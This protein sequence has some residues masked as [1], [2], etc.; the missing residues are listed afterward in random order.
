DLLAKAGFKNVFVGIESP[1][2]ASLNECKKVQNTRRD[3][4][5]AVRTIHHAGVQVM[6]GFIVGFDSD[7]TEIF[8]QQ[9]RFIRGRVEPATHAPEPEGGRQP[10]DPES[11]T[12]AS[13]DSGP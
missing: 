1:Q 2:A 6:A 3:L 11:E 12:T 8:D 9:R 13:A 7:T 4:V 5:E 10:V